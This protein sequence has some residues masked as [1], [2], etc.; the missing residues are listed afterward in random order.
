[1]GWIKWFLTLASWQGIAGMA[2]V[3][4]AILT[5][6][7]IR[8]ASKMI[9]QGE[10][11]KLASRAPEWEITNHVTLAG[12]QVSV[13]DID[14]RNVGLGPAKNVTVRFETDNNHHRNCI[15]GHGNRNRGTN[16][17]VVLENEVFW[18]QLNLLANEGVM[19][20]L[21]I[22]ECYSVFHEKITR[23]FRVHGDASNI[24]ARHITIQPKQISN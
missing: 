4:A 7:A 20:G 1:M 8:Q 14:F 23:C 3:G 12:L 15:N 21:V 11:A 19:D 17:P 2:Q 9:R 10:Q 5:I 24:Q 13:A 18:V 6:I 22:L 16:T